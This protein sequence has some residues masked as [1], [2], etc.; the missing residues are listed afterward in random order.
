[1]RTL[2]FAKDYA[3]AAHKDQL[4]DGKPY[5]FHLDSVAIKVKSFGEQFQIVAYLHDVI[6]DTSL[7]YVRLRRLSRDSVVIY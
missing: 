4:Y 1:M 6:E 5:S 3:I 2:D 7:T